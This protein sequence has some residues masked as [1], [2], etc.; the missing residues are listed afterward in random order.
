[1]FGD[2]ATSAFLFSEHGASHQC[3]VLVKIWQKKQTIT[4]CGCGYGLPGLAGPKGEDGKDGLDGI[5][6]PDGMPGMDAITIDVVRT[7]LCFECPPGLNL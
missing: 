5:P 4:G 1:M 6:G 7:E 2:S 3:N